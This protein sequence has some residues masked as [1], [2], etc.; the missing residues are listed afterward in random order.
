MSL[1]NKETNIETIERWLNEGATLKAIE[2][3]S[4][5][6]N[7]DIISGISI[8][9]G[10]NGIMLKKPEESRGSVTMT[11]TPAAAQVG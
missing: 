9:G 8:T 3:G 4:A 11:P 2:L 7:N 1:G 6:V 10:Q 5:I